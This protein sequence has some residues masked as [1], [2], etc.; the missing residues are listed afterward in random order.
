M[1]ILTNQ[2]QKLIFGF[3]DGDIRADELYTALGPIPIDIPSLLLSL[4]ESAVASEKPEEASEAIGIANSFK[5]H[6]DFG[7]QAVPWLLAL[8]AMTGHYYHEDIVGILQRIKDVRSVEVLYETALCYHTHLEYDE[9]SDL[10]RKCTWALADVGNEAAY[11][12]LQLLTASPNVHI[13][14]YA[15]K[16]IDSWEKEQGRKAFRFLP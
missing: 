11:R 7:N 16:R 10:A 9:D 5:N 14:G 1:R 8:L 4:L 6:K 3:I 2:Q 15:Q 12:K 13:V